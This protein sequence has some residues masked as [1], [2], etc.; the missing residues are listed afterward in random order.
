MKLRRSPAA[1]SAAGRAVAGF[2]LALALWFGFSA[3]YERVL[4]AAAEVLLRTTERPALT[5]LA[6]REGEFL[7]ERADFPPAAARP[8]LPAADLHFNFALLAALFALGRRPWKAG[9]VAAFLEG[10]GLL[11]LTHVV[12]LAF[13]VRS[14]YATGL[15]A[16]SAAHYG[17]V[18]RNFWSAGFHFYQIAGRF[19]APFAIWWLLRRDEQLVGGAPPSRNRRARRD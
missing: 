2:L 6:A 19:A 14:L 11:F 17:A 3:P 18:A 7:V 4:A 12:A 9:S 16:W 5:R 13:Q 8:G 10:C 15:G 1:I